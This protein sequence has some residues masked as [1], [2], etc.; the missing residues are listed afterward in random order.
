MNQA[1]AVTIFAISLVLIFTDRIHRTIVAVAGASVMVA[2]GH[3]LGFYGEGE[4]LAA[5]DFK[6]IGLLLGMMI[7]VALLEPTGFFEYLALRAGRLSR[8]EP[9]RLFILLGVVTTVL[10]M[11]LD[12]VTTVVVIAPVTLVIARVLQVDAVPLLIAEAMLSNVGGIATLVGDPPN[13]LIGSAA[14]LSFNDFLTHSLPIIAIVWVVALLLLIYL[15]RRALAVRPRAGALDELHPAEALKQPRVAV[16]VLAVLAGAV[17]LFLLQDL[18]E[19][20]PAFVAMG[21]AAAGL[22][23]VRPN[24]PETLEHVEWSMLIFFARLFVMVGGLEAAGVLEALA[25]RLGAA[26]GA[27]PDPARRRARFGG[28]PALGGGRQHPH[29]DR[30]HPGDRRPGVLGRE[31]RASLVGAGLRRRPR[32]QRDH[33]RVDRQH[34]RGRTRGA[35][36]DTPQLTGVDEDRV[37]DALRDVLGREPALRGAVPGPARISRP[38]SSSQ[39]ARP[40]SRPGPLPDQ[41][42]KQPARRRAT[43]L[44]STARSVSASCSGSSS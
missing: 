37:S 14:H 5:V 15:F 26:A 8:G 13:I 2:A 16:T 20:S 25:D 36:G 11:F 6:T 29:H 40:P 4:A 23:L 21:A 42:R 17:I 12:N 22:V 31:R 41:P 35:G 19:V 28:R 24:V 43:V 34:R 10:S 1:A 32:G 39:R 38:P 30:P 18:L 27:A 44:L 33:H 9:L 3:L 7:L